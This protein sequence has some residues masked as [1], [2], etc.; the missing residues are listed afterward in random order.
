MAELHFES[1]FGPLELY[2]GMRSVEWRFELDFEKPSSADCLPSAAFVDFCSFSTRSAGAKRTRTA[3][4]SDYRRRRWTGSSRS[5]V[6]RSAIRSPRAQ[7]HSPLD[8]RKVSRV[9]WQTAGERR[10]YCHTVRAAVRSQ[11][12]FP[13]CERAIAIKKQLESERS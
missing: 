12:A 11:I 6:S 5:Q 2:I 9:A 13:H 1:H 10:P 7:L 4:P 3:P 8:F